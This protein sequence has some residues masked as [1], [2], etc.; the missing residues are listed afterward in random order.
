MGERLRQVAVV[1]PGE[2]SAGQEEVAYEV[3]ARLARA[4]LLVVTGGLG[5]VMAAAS[6]GAVEA[7]GRTLGLLPGTDPA[8]AN[9]WVQA[10]V[11]TGL[12]QA[13]NALVVGSAAALVAVGGGWG[14][15]SEV[16]LAL[17]DG[18]PVV[19]VGSWRPRPPDGA[20]SP[21]VAA[22]TAADAVA[23][24]LHLSLPN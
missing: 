15:L 3:G 1:G 24:L 7:G 22:A 23:A 10:V 21:V 8:A 18:R 16:A 13:R 4:G 17:R 14:T 11:P 9:P 2:A 12:G 20:P 19:G 5:G 6:R